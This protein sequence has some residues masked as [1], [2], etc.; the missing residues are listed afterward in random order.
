MILIIHWPLSIQLTTFNYFQ[1]HNEYQSIIFLKIFIIIQM[2]LMNNFYLKRNI[3][4]QFYCVH[5]GCCSTTVR[6]CEDDENTFI[7]LQT[8]SEKKQ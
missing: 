4:Y 7:S 3:D 8:K 2:K 6:Q 1:K 5:I